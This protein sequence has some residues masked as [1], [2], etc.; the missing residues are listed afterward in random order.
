MLVAIHGLS[1][2]LK[3]SGFFDFLIMAGSLFQTEIESGT[4]LVLDSSLL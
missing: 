1:L 3:T 2:V 4:K